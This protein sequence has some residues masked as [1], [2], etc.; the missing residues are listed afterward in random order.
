MS[1]SAVSV[2]APPVREWAR[3]WRVVLAVVALSITSNLHTGALGALMEPLNSG[4]GWSRAQVSSA[5]TIICLGVLLVGPIAGAVMDRIGPRKLALICLAIY[6]LAFAAV[7][8]SGPGIWSWYLGW[9]IV[10]LLYPGISSLTQTGV[11]TQWFDRRRGMALA[12]GLTGAGVSNAVTPI[13][14]AQIIG[15]FDWRAAFYI[16][17]GCIFMFVLPIVVLFLHDHHPPAGARKAKAEPVRAAVAGASVGEAL[18]NWTFWR[19]GVS[20]SVASA[21]IGAMAIHL[22]PI[23]RDAGLDA[24]TA[25]GYAALMGPAL[26]GGRLLG[27]WLLDILPGKLVAAGSLFLPAT[28]CLLLLFYNGEPWMSVTV[29]IF[30][31]AAFGLESDVLPYLTGRYFGLRRYGAIFA[32]VY[33][34]YAAA[35]GLAPMIAGWV[36]DVA[37]SYDAAL[38]VIIAALLVGA[39]LLASLPPTPTLAPGDQPEP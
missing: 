11:I 30:A 8:L 5:L 23:M 39:A 9:G 28:A 7:G 34:L 18:R 36:F 35:F 38:K 25:A 6:P 27:G 21:A 14:V 1:T 24:A 29:A 10:S 15:V 17:G 31:G 12:L 22:Q 26:I 19:I 20:I 4:F 3:G 33:G 2:D 16:L 32:L 37:G 13:L